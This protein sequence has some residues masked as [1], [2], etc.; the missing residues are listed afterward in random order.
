MDQVAPSVTLRKIDR[1]NWREAI[2]QNVAPGQ[3]SFV[4]SP[5]KS[6]AAAFVRQYGDHFEYVPMGIYDGERM[7]GYVSLLCEPNSIDN[8]WIDDIMIDARW[9]GRG[10]GRAALGETIRFILAAYPRCATVKLACHRM[11][12]RAASLYLSIGFRP[13]GEIDAYGQPQYA[14]SGPALAACR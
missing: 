1:S 3:E 12:T 8:Y 11:N 9:Q 4:S 2:A 10:Y 6:L 14:L 5:V 13:T 7:V